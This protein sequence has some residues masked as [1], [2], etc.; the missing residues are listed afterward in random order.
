LPDL[1]LYRLAWVAALVAASL[2]LLFLRPPDVLEPSEQ[3]VS[4]D[5]DRAMASLRD[6]AQRFP[7][8][9]AGSGA[10]ARC[11]AW[12]ADQLRGLGLEPHVDEFTAAVNGQEVT[13]RNVWAA[14]PGGPGGAIVVLAGRDSPPRSTQGADNNASGIA[15][16]LELARVYATTSH[17][18]TIVF[19]WTDGDT[20]GDLGAEEFAARCSGQRTLAVICLRQIAGHGAKALSLNGW[21]V[22]PDV[23][24]PWLWIL[25]RA[26]A[27]VESN[28]RAPL[29]HVGAQLM[30]LA[31][32]ATPGGQSPFVSRGVP[33]LSISC[34][35]ATRDPAADTVDTVSVETLAKVGKTADRMVVTL[36]AGP[37]IP[38]PHGPRLFFSRYRDLG[39]GFVAYSFIVLAVPLAL[40]TIGL[41]VQLVRRHT[42][43]AV[44]WLRLALRLVPWY[45]TLGIVYLANLVGL[46]PR[47]PGA[48]VPPESAVAHSPRYL[49]VIL[50][51]LFLAVTYH[52]AM[53]I[54]HRLARRRPAAPIAIVTTAHTTLLAMAVVLA[55]LNPFSL[56]LVLPAAALWPIARPGPWWRS[57]LPV[58]AG[59][60]LF[61]TA[62]VYFALRLH[63]G[64]TVWWYFFLLLENRTIPA[65]PVLLSIAFV[66]AAALLGFQLH[67]QSPADDPLVA[68]QPAAVTGAGERRRAGG[69]PEGGPPA[70]RRRRR[71]ERR[72][73]DQ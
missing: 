55:A 14:A 64:W 52:Y 68:P 1:R 34:A 16:V 69:S 65:L 20:L 30:R 22:T 72:P 57:R 7:S 3:P 31:L 10:D 23:A 8:R 45:A 2:S 70:R 17:A 15:A 60:A 66:A 27:H 28:L 71:R 25:A 53:A 33:A 4:F 18:H 37:E 11:A 40:V 41:W 24:P 46:L 32:P 26:A 54:E 67:G 35:G 51:A 56:V 50:L 5:G 42:G 36:D 9:T 49:R 12:L 13:L 47:S 58:W 39:G 73:P 63:L 6:V 44:A 29:P 61:A 62:V 59:L 48:V 38:P 19:L 21:S 43:V